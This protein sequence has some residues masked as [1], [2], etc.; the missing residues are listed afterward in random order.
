MQPV[1]QPDSYTYELKVDGEVVLSGVTDDLARRAKEH[2]TR[3][4][5]GQVERVG[6]PITRTQALA[7]LREQS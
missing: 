6:G 7:W 1:E 5:K 3:W 2:R 4:P